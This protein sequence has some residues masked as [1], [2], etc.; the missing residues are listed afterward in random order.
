MTEDETHQKRGQNNQG[1]VPVST[2]TVTRPAAAEN[3]QLHQVC[4]FA[5]TQWLMRKYTTT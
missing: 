5:S 2:E 1:G 4:S 3:E